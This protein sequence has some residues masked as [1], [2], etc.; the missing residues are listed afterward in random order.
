MATNLLD[1]YDSCTLT[2]STS[3]MS[4]VSS[5][6]STHYFSFSLPEPICDLSVIMN[7][8]IFHAQPSCDSLFSLDTGAP[9]TTCNESWLSKVGWTPVKRI[10]FPDDIPPFRFAGHPIRALYGVCLSGKLTYIQGHLHPLHLFAFVLLDCP[11]P[12]LT[13]PPGPMSPRLRYMSSPEPSKS[14][15]DFKM[16]E[17]PP[18]HSYLAR[19]NI[20]HSHLPDRQ[21]HS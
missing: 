4:N 9:K 2:M 5:T 1:M 21:V 11:N 13:W 14:S 7:K 8:F 10:D 12:F 18:S 6:A 3:L 17:Y 19:L 20:V 16:A 15:Q